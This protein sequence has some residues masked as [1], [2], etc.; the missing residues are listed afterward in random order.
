MR[1]FVGCELPAWAAAALATW[2]S[3][4]AGEGLRPLAPASLHVTLFFLGERPDHSVPGLAA[5]L[6]RL[7]AAPV[8]LRTTGPARLGRVLALELDDIGGGL[9]ALHA[10]GFPGWEAEGR[11]F[12]PHVT[13]ARMRGAVVRLP[14]LPAPPSLA[15]D[16][17]A[18]TLFRSHAGSRYEPLERVLLD[19]G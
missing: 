3:G 4:V 8:A 17:P 2:T 12:R 14:D 9:T 18:V 16:A 15:F 19:G 13:V 1:L 6:R 7:P 5:A 10:C 11:A